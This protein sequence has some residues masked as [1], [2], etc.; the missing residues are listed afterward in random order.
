MEYDRYCK[1]RK[2][3]GFKKNLIEFLGKNNKSTF[4]GDRLNKLGRYE[5]KINR[6]IDIR[7][8]LRLYCVELKGNAP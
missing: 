3:A 2:R 4:L 7:K 6:K 1:D 5:K 8:S